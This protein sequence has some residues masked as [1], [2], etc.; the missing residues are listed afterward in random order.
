[1]K[2]WDKGKTVY[3][4]KYG[5]DSSWLNVRVCPYESGK[6]TATSGSVPDLTTAVLRQQLNFQHSSTNIQK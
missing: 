2:E 6:F 4:T 1:M 5:E 3:M